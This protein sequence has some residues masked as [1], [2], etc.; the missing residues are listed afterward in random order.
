MISD[1]SS[2]CT[3]QFG[4]RAVRIECVSFAPQRL[5]AYSNDK[6][7]VKQGTTTWHQG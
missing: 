2:T 7:R 5:G 4:A 1:K 3:A 6:F